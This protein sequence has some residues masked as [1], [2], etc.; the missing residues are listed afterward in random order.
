MIEKVKVLLSKL[1]CFRDKEAKK[2]QP[3]DLGGV[4]A[5]PLPIG[6]VWTSAPP[7]SGGRCEQE[8]EQEQEQEL[9]QD[10]E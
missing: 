5:L 2:P 6:G 3:L 9:E 7:Y 1:L 4:R 8:Q 10:R